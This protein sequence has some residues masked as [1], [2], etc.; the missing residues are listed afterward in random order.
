MFHFLPCPA[1]LVPQESHHHR[2]SKA[3]RRALHLSVLN[4]S[5]TEANCCFLGK[6][7]GI[8]SVQM[9]FHM[10]QG[11]K[12]PWNENGWT[13]HFQ[14]YGNNESLDPGT[15]DFQCFSY[16]TFQND[17][18]LQKRSVRSACAIDQ[19]AFANHL[20]DLHIDPPGWLHAMLQWFDNLTSDL[21]VPANAS[22]SQVPR[23]H[24]RASEPAPVPSGIGESHLETLTS[25]HH[26][27]RNYLQKRNCFAKLWREGPLHRSGPQVSHSTGTTQDMKRY[28]KMRTYA[29]LCKATHWGSQHIYSWFRNAWAFS[30]PIHEIKNSRVT[31]D[32]SSDMIR[33]QLWKMESPISIPSVQKSIHRKPQKHPYLRRSATAEGSW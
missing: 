19:V 1:R 12:L 26:T 4:L 7:D 21:G 16:T 10:C 13:I 22:E 29:K 30:C 17:F 23:V 15:Y 6:L 18:H 9:D 11:S 31:S 20:Q 33:H 14:W 25:S 27:A 32:K 24:P 3:T 8:S 2:H 5:G 28:E